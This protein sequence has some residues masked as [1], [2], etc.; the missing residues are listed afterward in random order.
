MDIKRITCIQ[1]NGEFPDF[2]H[3]LVMPDYGMP[4]IGTILSEAGYD[5]KVFMEHV[6]PPEWS[7]IAQSD[8]VCFSTLSAGAGK[9][10][11]LARKIKSQFGIPVIIGGTHASYFPESCLEHCDYV[12]LGEG[13]ETIIELVDAL[14]TGRDIRAV[15]GVAYRDAS[16]VQRTAPRAG[17]QGFNT[18]PD[19]SLI[20]GYHRMD[21]LGILKQRKIPL[22]TVQSSR[23][24]QFKCTFCIV[25][26]M[27]PAGYRK[28]DVESVIRD[29]QDKRQYG[30]NLLFV[31]NDFAA[32]RPYTK[33][34]LRRMIEEDLGFDILVLTRVE[35]ARD[36][37]LLSLM[38][39]AG[40]SHIYQGYESVQPET[41]VGYDK[42]QSLESIVTA[43]Q[44]LHSFG[45]GISGSF[46]LGADTDTLET[47]RQ[48]VDFVLDQK[49]RI[50]YFFPVW[51]HY[52]EQIRGYKAII[53][54]YR[55]IFRGWRYCD[56]NFV[57]HFPLRM[58]PSQLQRAIIEAHRTVFSAAQILKSL[59]RGNLV[60]A[61]EKILHR[62][63]WH[64]IEAALEDYVPFLETLEDGLY[65]RSD[66]LRE[67]RLA[68]RVGDDGWWTFK[69]GNRAV[70]TLG[71][72]P[73]ELPIV[74]AEP[75]TCVSSH[76]L[77]RAG[78]A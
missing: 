72:S 65:D 18:V 2:C 16:R 64:T 8:L 25:N 20:E 44:K 11:Q 48:T 63:M 46:V 4:L 68:K 37:E 30:R 57:T 61:K 66:R 31:D 49:L 35:V 56:G 73:P 28:R 17:P 26:T 50:A 41:L 1:L 54:W 75:L 10:Y 19:F 6:K 34:L 9:T 39:Q 67:D 22:L 60:D 43:I 13:D 33:T 32:V 71:L 14:S 27:F 24:C 40:I 62:Y 7:R 74:S 77:P 70:Q 59:R 76:Q 69:D 15:A 42:K 5:V 3:R 29:L 52:P 51:G 36:D 53:P 21:P 23:G 45:F 47:V 55:S 38:R 12:V 58:R 78:P